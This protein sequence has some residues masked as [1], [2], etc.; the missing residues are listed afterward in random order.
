MNSSSSKLKKS[1]YL[2]IYSGIFASG[3]VSLFLTLLILYL[4]GV[5]DVIIRI[6]AF[7]L[8]LISFAIIGTLSYTKNYSE[9][10][11]AR[12]AVP[13]VHCGL[14]LA[15]SG[16]G[17]TGLVI[18]PGL[19]FINGFDSWCL[20]LGLIVGFLIMGTI[21]A[22]FCR[23]RGAYTIPS[24]LGWRFKSKILRKTAAVIVLV[25]MLLFVSAELQVATYATQQIVGFTKI[26]SVI[27]L[28]A[29]LVFCLPFGGM[30][31]LST[32][33][34]AQAI[35][36]IIAVVTPAAVIGVIET[37]LPIAQLSHGSVLQTIKL[38]E[39]AQNINSADISSMF[40]YDLAGQ[41]LTNI[42]G[43]LT[44]PYLSL[45]T[46]SFLLTVITVMLGVACAPWLL[47]TSGITYGLRET[48]KSFSWTIFFAGLV[49]TSLSSLAIF[50]RHDLMLSVVGK[51]PADFPRWFTSDNISSPISSLTNSEALKL[52]SVAFYRDSVLFTS[53]L[54]ADLPS[55]FVYLV[56]VG[57]IC[58]SLAASGATL[59]AISI[60]LTEDILKDNN[61]FPIARHILLFSSRIVCLLTIM[62]SLLVIN[63]IQTDPL[64]LLLWAYAII[65]SA[66]F[67]V[68]L[69]SIW[70][71]KMNVHAAI[72]SLVV[73][74]SISIIAI[75]SDD[76]LPIPLPVPIMGLSGLIPAFIAAFIFAKF[77][78]GYNQFI[79]KI[80][81][82]MRV[83]R[84]KSIRNEF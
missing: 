46:F 41:I 12:R 51:L 43:E 58:A 8:P 13:A 14:I 29:V 22:P 47:P 32:V 45:S 59:S 52:S 54:T 74:F 68:L 37:N 27:I 70:W 65:A 76:T 34:S 69:L 35:A 66:I 5:P 33:S 18:I 77:S 62:S 79:F 6:L 28:A 84:K 16:L 15:T 7:A 30:R 75:I 19:L 55:I 56:I 81:R 72:A 23:K 36:V 67:P 1:P 60:L 4:L 71:K 63:I 78:P 9:F 61:R 42:K 49:I 64:Q 10:F 83:S 3:F 26:Y 31:A 11:T 40:E 53:P 24:Y 38:M 25:P 82:N 73:G 20:P 80:I 57:V 21:I 44:A 17:G 39:T 48:R 50:M 2:G